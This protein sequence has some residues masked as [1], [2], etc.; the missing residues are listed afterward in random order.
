MKIL[1]EEIAA[2]GIGC[3]EPEAISSGCILTDARERLRAD[4]VEVNIPTHTAKGVVFL[5][6]AVNLA[7]K[8]ID[9]GYYA[10]K[11]AVWAVAVDVDGVESGWGDDGCFYLSAPG[12]GVICTHDPDGQ[13]ANFTATFCARR[14]P[15]PWS[16]VSRQWK[17]F[18]ALRSERCRKWLAWLTDSANAQIVSDW[19][20]RRQARRAGY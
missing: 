9:P 11:A 7:A 19:K 6:L 20:N 12:A 2:W 3:P 17:A 5:A 1:L 16:G 4:G 18:S 13:L 15:T 10:I 14:W 8:E